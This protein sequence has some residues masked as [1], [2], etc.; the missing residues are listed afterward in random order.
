MATMSEEIDRI[1][2]KI[3]SYEESHEPL[4]A[5]M[6]SDFAKF[7]ILE[8]YVPPRVEGIAPKDAYTTNRPRKLAE[9]SHNAIAMAERVV[10]VE[11]D[12]SKEEG[13]KVND[14]FESWTIGVLNNATKN[15][16]D[17]AEK[18]IIDEL[19]F[20]AITRG[21][22]VAA[23]A[24]LFKRADGS[25]Y[26][27]ITPID[28]RHL[29]FERGAR[30][31]ILWAAIV[32]RRT[33][34]Q[35][36]DEYPNFK[37]D[38]DDTEDD[39]NRKEKVY[40]YYFTQGGKGKKAGEH[41]NSVI[42]ARKY[43]RNKVRT[44]SVNF[45]IV[46]RLCGRNPGTAN[47]SFINDVNESTDILG[48]RDVGDSIWGVMR[49]SN[50][51]RNRSMTYR[52]G[53]M[54]REMSGVW[55]MHSP[56]A[57]KDIEGI[58]DEPGRVHNLDSDANEKLE[59][60]QMQ[61]LGQDAQVY[62]AVVA[63]DELGADLPRA[64]YGNADIPVSGAVARLLGRTISARIDPYIKPIESLLEGCIAN[65]E[66]Q[67]A[68][69]QYEAIMVAGRTRMGTNFNRPIKP[70]DIE[71]HGLLSIK[72][73][74]ELP[75]DKMENYLIAGQAVKRDG[76]TGESL[77]SYTGARDDILEL[78]SGDREEQRNFAAI[79][80]TSTPMLALTHQISAAMNEGRQDVALFL[81]QE[82]EKLNR[83]EMMEQLAEELAFMQL[84][85]RDPAAAL[86]GG[87]GAGGG[88]APGGQQ[89]LVDV[90]GQPLVGDSGA[91]QGVDSRG[92]GQQGQAGVTPVPSP[93][94]GLNG[95]A[96]PAL[97]GIEPNPGF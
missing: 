17:M 60:L 44:H 90:N 40:D 46:I 18:P 78:E 79:A 96:D 51:A 69:G 29:V 85:D 76:Q 15:R 36:R 64:A 7:W 4:Y 81:F 41:L 25:T 93:V 54:A 43:A 35:I 74:P 48:I 95:V 94:A 47:F 39:G 9:A 67:Y 13:R 53:I 38:G 19:G 84:F 30:G 6:D 82:V 21:W 88:G 75:E 55:A 37:F 1:T 57:E 42:I 83:R 97:V 70:E 8:E 27:D 26:E 22:V 73:K 91:I 59:L 71:D 12:E 14:E 65:M 61:R 31:N 62:D 56:G 86:G 20:R 34:S 89:G 52:T 28:P 5:R 68:T 16:L 80:K 49:G 72:L 11:N 32:T 58:V 50:R 33:R 24:Q 63:E 87:V 77:M 23:R 3:L 2:Q 92:F 45:P 10:R 66:A